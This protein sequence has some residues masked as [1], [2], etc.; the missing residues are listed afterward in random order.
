MQG[1]F[2]DRKVSPIS[3][4]A[5]KG[6]KGETM[7]IQ[8]SKYVEYEIF[9]KSGVIAILC[10]DNICILSCQKVLIKCKQFNGRWDVSCLCSYNCKT[11]NSV[12]TLHVLYSC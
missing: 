2:T 4:W 3:I 9:G 11:F 8:Y 7:N 12:T 1:G 6:P 5:E 10:W